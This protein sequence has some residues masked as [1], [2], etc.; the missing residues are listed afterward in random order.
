MSAASIV[1]QPRDYPLIVEKDVRIPLRDGTSI[2][3]D[4]FRPDGGSERF[5]VIMNIGP[6]QKDKVWVPPP[7]V[8][9]K[10]NSYMNWEAANPTWWCPRGYALLRVDSRG[11]G[12]SPGQ[13]DPISHQEALDAYDC[14]EWVA[15]QSR[16]S[17]NVGTLGVSYHALFQWR[18][19]GLQPPS[20]KAIIPWE[21]WADTYRDVAFHGGIAGRFIFDWYINNTAIHLLGKPRNYNPHVFNNNLAWR[22]LRNDLD[23]EFWRMCSARLDKIKVPLYSVGN[24]GGFSM[25]LRGN[26]EGFM[27]AASKHKKLR[28]HTGTHFGPFHSEEGRLDQLRF[29]DHWLKGIDTGIMD[30]PPVKLEIRT[31]GSFKPYAFRFENEWP[32]ARTQW[33]RMYLRVD[34]EPSN[35]AD[36][37]EGELVATPPKTTGKLTYPAGPSSRPG[38]TPRGVSFETPPMQDD[39]EVTGPIVLNLWVSSTSEDMD[40]FA[41]IRNI[42]PDGQDVCEIGQRA[43][44]V[45]CVTKGWLRASRRKLDPERSLPYRP[46][47]AHDGY[48]WLKPGE[49]VECQVEI[50]PTS[51]VFKK[52]HKLRLDIAPMDGVG[53]LYFTHFHV[54]YN[55]GAES[56]IYAGGDKES[57]LLLPVIPAK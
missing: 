49:I 23:S 25:H 8:E 51:M 4:V 39:T 7:D 10:P 3:A 22:Y 9:E 48:Q 54:D 24:W 31:G 57:Y 38:K 55:A 53:T 29:M 1:S 41:T 30:E 47:H 15:R 6:Y 14:V 21:G 5:P 56:T 11:S 12:K 52:G 2:C 13:S 17:G 40:I 27:G 37:V 16:C 34:R 36:A 19:A 20:L 50:W 45:P 26:T 46:Y 32:L 28:I 42:G 44:P 18:L 33:I 43:D 35:N